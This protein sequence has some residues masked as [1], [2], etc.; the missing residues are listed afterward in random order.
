MKDRL[1]NYGLWVAI[2]SFIPL[3]LQ[4]FGVDVLPQNYNEIISAFLGILVLAGILSNP[5]IGKGFSDK[6]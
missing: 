6:K 3:L 1:E 5:S 2:F 4:G